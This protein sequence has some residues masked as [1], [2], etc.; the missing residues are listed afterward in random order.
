MLLKGPPTSSPT[1]VLHGTSPPQPMSMPQQV[2]ALRQQPPQGG[3]GSDEDD[4]SNIPSLVGSPV[5]L[6][7]QPSNT[8]AQAAAAAQQRASSAWQVA[9]PD[10]AAGASQ[11]LLEARRS[12][13]FALEDE[14]WRYPA[15]GAPAAAAPKKA[16][17]HIPASRFIWP[18][19]QGGFAAAA[20]QQQASGNSA[21]PLEHA[22]ESSGSFDFGDLL[23]V[24]RPRRS[25]D[26]RMADAATLHM[27][28]FCRFLP[29]VSLTLCMADLKAL[30]PFPLPH[31]HHCHFC[32]AD[33]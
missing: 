29:L 14:V 12:V 8:A 3:S 31:L 4:E 28:W 2:P 13:S 18:E 30:F 25:V 11:P 1:T 5:L 27:V 23:E 15:D 21:Q 9:A 33:C 16:P 10:Q 24:M 32:T 26:V 6:F 20:G 7:G 17:E 22:F 19:G